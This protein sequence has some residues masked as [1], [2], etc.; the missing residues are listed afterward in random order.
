V[1]KWGSSVKAALRRSAN[2]ISRGL[3]PQARSSLRH[4]ATPAEEGVVLSARKPIIRVLVVSLAALALGPVAAAS[5]APTVTIE[6]P[7]SGSTAA[8]P[9]PTFSG[10]AQDP[11]AETQHEEDELTLKVFK[12]TPEG[13]ELVQKLTAKLPPGSWTLGPIQ[14]LADG[15]YTALATLTNAVEETGKSEVIFTVDTS[16]PPITITSPES[17]GSVSE[18]HVT[19]SGSAGT[20]KGDLPTITIRLY[21]GAKVEPPAAVESL[22][23]EASSG[24]WSATFGGVTPGTYT[25]QAEQSDEAGNLGQSPPV[26]FSVE[27]DPPTVETKAASA[28]SQT[29]ATLNATVNP[30]GS[31]VGACSFEYGTTADY[32]KTAPCSPAPGPGSSPVAV[33]ASVT[34]LSPNTAYHFRVVATN[35]GGPSKG[36]DAEFKTTLP[37]PPTVQTGEYIAITLVGGVLTGAVNPNAAEV[38][39]CHFEYGLTK[40]YGHSV[41]CATPRGSG[42]SLVSVVA[43]INGLT[44]NAIYHFRIVATNAGGTSYGSDVTFSA[45]FGIASTFDNFGTGIPGAESAA[46][47]EGATAAAR[48]ERELSAQIATLLGRQLAL[49][50]NG[51]KIASLLR[52][53]RFSMSFTALEAGT[54]VVDWYEVPPGAHLARKT[55]ARPVLVASGRRHVSAAG[56]FKIKLKLTAAGKRLLKRAKRFKVTAKAIFTPTGKRPITA[57]K[58]FVL[59][60]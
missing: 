58:T 36:A 43:S 42:T 56:T 14:T 30:N 21:A 4:V 18:S 35:G 22:V 12:G 13:G 40:E 3:D 37:D 19:L 32:G 38:S 47:E 46:A 23:V 52:S 26:T 31:E 33:S 15:T 54:V 5:A 57:T 41:S 25:A 48:K 8:N 45:T 51:A 11:V 44:L 20:E 24:T 39:E 6:R 2:R 28:V 17:G 53:G 49:P 29:G 9:A 34:G 27:P 50:R 59:K 55:K 1:L 10:T 7:A 16:P 60:R